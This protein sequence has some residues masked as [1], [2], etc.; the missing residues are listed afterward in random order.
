[1]KSE[2][3]VVWGWESFNQMKNADSTL[4]PRTS[5]FTATA[6]TLGTSR[7]CSAINLYRFLWFP[8]CGTIYLNR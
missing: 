5:S 7:T 6:G 3:I 2:P 8:L 4:L 1:M